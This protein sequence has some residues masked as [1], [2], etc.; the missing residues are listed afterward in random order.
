MRL[1]GATLL[2]L[3]VVLSMAGILLAIGIPSYASMAH[4]S[5][6]SSFT[7]ELVS[8]LHLTRSE[9]IKRASHAVLC[10]S[11]DGTSC[12]ASGGWQQGW[13]V[14]HDPDNDAIRDPGEALILARPA[15]PAGYRLTGNLPVKKY[16]SYSSGGRTRMISGA[17][18]FGSLILC[19]DSGTFDSGRKIIISSSGR[20]RSEKIKLASCP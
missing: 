14:F 19:N 10:T 3:L 6:L 16:V 7:N 9:A 12:A 17:W 11:S 1:S 5:R 2:E 18:Q 4:A 13:I 15:L 20:P 8:A